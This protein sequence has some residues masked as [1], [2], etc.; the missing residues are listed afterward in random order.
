MTLHR[1]RSSLPASLPW[2]ECPPAARNISAQVVMLLGR[3]LLAGRSSCQ[4]QLDT[5]VQLTG[6]G[7]SSQVQCGQSVVKA[8]QVPL[9]CLAA[10]A[11]GVGGASLPSRSLQRGPPPLTKVCGST[12]LTKVCGSHPLTKVQLRS[13]STSS[14]ASFPSP[15][16]SSNNQV[17]C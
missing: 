5:A 12:P 4:Q 7:S 8:A 13:I 17:T 6:G 11:A 3:R 9:R 16:S 1:H 15:S 14:T 10:A 2:G